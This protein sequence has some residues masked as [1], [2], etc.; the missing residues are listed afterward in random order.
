MSTVWAPVL[1]AL[2]F[3]D[4]GSADKP[5]DEGEGVACHWEGG[6]RV[7]WAHTSCMKEHLE[8][9]VDRMKVGGGWAPK[10]GTGS[11]LT[12]PV[13]FLRLGIQK[14]LGLVPRAPLLV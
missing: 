8:M 2:P 6:G 5:R 7:G 1:Y 11:S 10:M 3:M 14:A 9:T 4:P 13:R 12:V